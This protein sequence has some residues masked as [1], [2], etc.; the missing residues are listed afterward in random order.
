M[1]KRL[2][3]LTVALL[4]GMGNAG[5]AQASSDTALAALPETWDLAT[6][7]NYAKQH[8]ITIQSMRLTAASDA[9]D[10]IQSR[11]A[12]YPNLSGSA[13]EG[14]N[15]D[16]GGF[17]TNTNLGLSSS[18]VLY[19][20]G[21]LKNDIK[22]KD[23][24]VQAAKLNVAAAEND[25]TL[26][27]TQAF[28]NILL[29]R[30]NIIYYQDLVATTD[31][32]VRQGQQRFQAGVLA[33][34][35]YLELQATLA[36]D[37][38]SL[39]LANNTLRQNTLVLKQMLQLP[40]DAPFTAAVTA[41]DSVTVKAVLTP[42]DEAETIA[43]KNRPEVKSGELGV[44]IQQTE[45]AKVRSGLKPTLSLGGSIG[46]NYTKN[47]INN[48][49]PQLNQNF[50][51]SLGLNLDVPILDRKVT[52]SNTEKAKI[53][54]DQARLS[55]Q[56]TKTTLAQHIEQAY[57][58]VENAR[59]QYEAA[60]EQLQYSEEAFRIAD[61]QLKIGVYDIVDYLQ[62]KNQYVQAQQSFIQAKYTA[63][64]YQKVYNFYIGIPVTE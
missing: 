57:I 1:F 34:K 56:D 32:Q 45:L 38:Y 12:R 36:S 27:I 22:S 55:L 61:Q 7:L 39:V 23:L 10:L 47:G 59:S 29:A 5:M 58:D 51:Q 44:Q 6:C 24:S 14:L 25:V 21:Y 37:K 26:S 64:L 9:Q 43:A 31:S 50:N 40:T 3:V 60:A 19:Q 53:A 11:A 42:L 33:R 48:Y 52:R 18:M 13:G 30:E 8:N 2:S 62:Q 15:H 4:I 20:G 41:A 46:T 49:F 17:F 16:Q 54:V 63:A 35:D 28:L